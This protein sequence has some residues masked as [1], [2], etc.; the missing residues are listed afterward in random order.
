VKACLR[1]LGTALAWVAMT[2]PV[3]PPQVASWWIQSAALWSRGSAAWPSAS[4]WTLRSRWLEPAGIHAQQFRDGCGA[5]SLA[6]VLHQHDVH[7]SQSLL[8]SILRQ[9]HGGTTLGAIARAAREF[10]MAGE[11]RWDSPEHLPTPAIVH[12]RRLH[13]VVLREI[14]PEIAE[15]L[16]PACGVVQVRTCDLIRQASGAALVFEP[17]SRNLL[18]ERMEDW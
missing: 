8:W 15:I 2:E 3:S 10:G 7:V 11:L 6:A 5:A 9:P 4:A 13:F 17:S 14:G 18:A 16:D 1:I 12:L